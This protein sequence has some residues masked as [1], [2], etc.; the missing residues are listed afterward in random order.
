ML[1]LH[2]RRII[3]TLIVQICLETVLLFYCLA[4]H[5]PSKVRLQLDYRLVG[6]D[7]T[8][9]GRALFVLLHGRGDNV[10]RLLFTKLLL[11]FVS[12]PLTTLLSH[13]ALKKVT[14]LIWTL[15]RRTYLCLI[16]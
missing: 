7:V 15:R 1:R 11:V 8:V 10:I 13:A 14:S 4:G 6:R 9:L 5:V 3:L 12:L 2:L 16:Q